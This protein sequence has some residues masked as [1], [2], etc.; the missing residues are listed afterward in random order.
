MRR[1]FRSRRDLAGLRLF[2]VARA[3]ARVSPVLPSG[4]QP[5]FCA[6]GNQPTLELHNGS[7][8]MEHQLACGGGCI[9]PLLQA[10]QIDFPAFEVLDGFQQFLERSSRSIKLNGQGCHPSREDKRNVRSDSLAVQVTAWVGSHHPVRGFRLAFWCRR[11]QNC[12][13]SAHEVHQR[14]RNMSKFSKCSLLE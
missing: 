1:I 3:G 5:V 10:D 9:D 12:M 8:D 13:T 14:V 4:R 2:L 11:A 7:K 6:L